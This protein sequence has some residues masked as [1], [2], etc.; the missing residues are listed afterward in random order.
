MFGVP[1][2]PEQ[3]YISRNHIWDARMAPRQKAWGSLH[4]F[5]RSNERQGE[6]CDNAKEEKIDAEVRR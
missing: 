4:P 6:K 3:Y 1:A 5:K 2:E